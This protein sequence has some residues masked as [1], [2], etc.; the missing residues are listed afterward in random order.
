MTETPTPFEHPANGPRIYDIVL[1]ADHTRIVD[2]VQGSEMLVAAARTFDILERPGV[3]EQCTRI[4]I[5]WRGAS[6]LPDWETIGPE[7]AA[8]FGD[9]LVIAE[10]HLKHA[11]LT[12]FS[13]I[14][15]K[16]GG[17]A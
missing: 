10:P 15:A 11:D 8:A 1:Y 6:Q 2:A 9:L 7:L 16:T 14:R 12:R 5:S 17:R 3:S 4:Y 13:G